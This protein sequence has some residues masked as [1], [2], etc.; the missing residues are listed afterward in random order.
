[1]SDDGDRM[2]VETAPLTRVSHHASRH[3]ESSCPRNC[4][5]SLV[6]RGLVP[7]PAPPSPFLSSW[8]LPRLLLLPLLPPWQ[9]PPSCA[10]PR[11]PTSQPLSADVP[12]LPLLNAPPPSSVSLFLNG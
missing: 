9:L 2:N 12:L 5:L 8:L 4:V 7:W 1:M 6:L 10:A 11:R 3:L